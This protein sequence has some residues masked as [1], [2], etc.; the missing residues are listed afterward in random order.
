MLCFLQYQYKVT[1]A[2]LLAV[3][4]D[5]QFSVS[6]DMHVDYLYALILSLTPRVAHSTQFF[7]QLT[8]RLKRLVR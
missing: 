7:Y 4:G 8:Y 6:L 1:D 3:I 5:M 2:V